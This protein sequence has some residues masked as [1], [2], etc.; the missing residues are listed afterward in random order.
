MFFL[1]KSEDSI[2]VHEYVYFAHTHFSES[3]H[4]NENVIHEYFMH[5]KRILNEILVDVT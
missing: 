4:R 5:Q 3:N 1:R 2:N